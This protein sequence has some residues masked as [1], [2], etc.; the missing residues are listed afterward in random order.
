[1]REDE[2][3]GADGGARAAEDGKKRKEES[4]PVCIECLQFAG[5]SADG[6]RREYLADNDCRVVFCLDGK[7]NWMVL[8]GEEGGEHPIPAGW[9]GFYPRLCGR[10]CA[11]CAPGEASR[12]LQLMFPHAALRMLLGDS[13]FP[14]EMAGL[15]RN[16]GFSGS[17]RETTPSMN[18]IIE[19]MQSAPH[20]DRNSGLFLAAK[21]LEL[22]ALSC[23]Y[24]G[25][26][27][28]LKIVPRDRAAIQKAMAIL[29]GSME[30]PPS[31][32]ELAQN[33]GMS[34]SKF[35]TLF[36]KVCGLPPYEHLRKIRMERAMELLA[37]GEMNVTETAME[38]GYSSISHFAKVFRKAFSVHPSRIHRQARVGVEPGNGRGGAR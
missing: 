5:R 38:V 31:L 26:S 6:S 19:G 25:A 17:V 24:E 36:P 33:V 34:A 15:E 23:S 10:C 27:R 20:R 12:V 16:A 29:E 8:A 9:F 30:A 4:M 11:V 2:W 3:K 1:M 14:S 22:L 32:G 18:R 7:I 28:D 13:M 37:G 21:A 35:K